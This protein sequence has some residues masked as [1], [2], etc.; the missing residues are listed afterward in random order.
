M[1]LKF[2]LFVFLDFKGNTFA[3]EPEAIKDDITG[4][5]EFSPY[6]LENVL[7]TTEDSEEIELEGEFESET[8][9]ALFAEL[10]DG[11]IYRNGPGKFEFGNTSFGHI[12]DPSAILSATRIR[13]GKVFFRQRFVQSSNFKNNT[14]NSRIIKPE[15]G[16]YAEPDDITTDKNGNAYGRREVFK[17]R[18]KFLFE[19]GLSTDNTVVNVMHVAGHLMSLTD[20]SY[21][22]LHDFET[23]ETKDRIDINYSPNIPHGIFCMTTSSHPVLDKETGD[24]WDMAGCLD[25]MTNEY[26]IPK[27]H[28]HPIVWRG[29]GHPKSQ[30]P[31]P[32]TKEQIL[33]SIEF[34][35]AIDSPK[36]PDHPSAMP[37]FHSLAR[38]GKYL[39]LPVGGT[40][41]DMIPMLKNGIR[42]KKPMIESL[43]FLN[44][45]PA[46]FLIFDREKME[47]ESVQPLAQ[48]F[49]H[50]HVVNSFIDEQD[51]LNIDII[52][53][54]PNV[55][56]ALELD[57]LKTTKNEY[58]EIWSSII[59]SGKPVRFILGKRREEFLQWADV[60]QSPG[61]TPSLNFP[62]FENGGIDFP[63]LNPLHYGKDYKH[64]W[65]CGFGELLSDRIY[66]VNME[67]G[68]R[69]IYR[70]PNYH[71][72]EPVF[73]T[74]EKDDL[75]EN[76]G[77]IASTASPLNPED[78]AFIVFLNASTMKEV[79][80]FYF[81]QGFKVPISFHGNYYRR[82]ETT[83]N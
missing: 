3:F 27:I 18:R 78:R 45:S 13:D 9:Q 76:Q 30:Y 1:A 22:H 48:A 41:L 60:V 66:Y 29:V 35:P 53:A 65:T 82:E 21:R 54:N 19:E 73:L 83:I 15:V 77:V 6:G 42:K 67:T 23:L 72:S 20:S 24:L 46:R 47:W 32:W 33:S 4:F 74:P 34:G 39:I 31:T 50:F 68:E 81:P 52:E 7:K 80:R 55:M 36:W 16:T 58:L 38:A 44:T 10:I 62:C 28:I 14:E 75:S 63:V 8:T 5:M 12:F 43:M 79:A 51:Q 11:V 49:S 59:P 26:N 2:L 71:F 64:Y 37:Y 17:N 56:Q 70:V 57:N 40:V 69:K 61:I 25:F